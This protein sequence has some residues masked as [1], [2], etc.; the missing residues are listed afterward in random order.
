MALSAMAC[1]GSLLGWQFTISQTGKLAA[2]DGLFPGFLGK[3]NSK[4]AP[5]V[6]MIIIGIVQ[7]MFAL[8]T[9]SPTLGETFNV[10]VDLSV[11]TNVI[12]YIM[13]L[14]GL[15][16]LMRKAGVEHNV[17]L[18]NSLVVII[19]VAYS[20][21]ALYLS[22]ATAVIGGLL[23]MTFGYLIYGFMAP[24]FEVDNGGANL[25]IEA[26]ENAAGVEQ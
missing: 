4:D 8:M 25:Q 10:L 20:I 5:V 23:I 16:V 24:K 7:T 14:T 13:A 6:G 21:M 11:V 19:A 2:D 22:G 26:E 1:L 12:P 9:A 18:R 3:V 15:M 17:Y